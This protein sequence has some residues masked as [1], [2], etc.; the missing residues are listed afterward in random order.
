MTNS[1]TPKADELVANLTTSKEFRETFEKDPKAALEAL[2]LEVTDTTA[3]V[4]KA[5]FAAQQAGDGMTEAA[6]AIPVPIPVPL[7]KR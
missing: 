2:G 4:I 7:P 3:A 1:T 5:S 6:D